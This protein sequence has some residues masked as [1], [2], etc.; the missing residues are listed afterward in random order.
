MWFPAAWAAPPADDPRPAVVGGVPAAPGAWPEVVAVED[1]NGDVGCTGTLVTP[2]LVVTAAHCV[3][4]A[5]A[6]R[7]GDVDPT[8]GTRIPV[9]GV[10]TPGE[11]T[12]GWDVAVLWLAV[13][14]DVVPRPIAADC[15]APVDGET[16]MIVG[17]GATASDADATA[18]P[19]RQ[20]TTRVDDADCGP[21]RGCRPGI[22][23]NGELVAGGGGVDSCR[24]DSG[25]PLYVGD[26]L[27]GWRIAGFASRAADP[28]TVDCGD[29]GI[30]VRADAVADWVEA[31]TGAA[32]TRP[33]CPDAPN[34]APAPIGQTVGAPGGRATVQLDPRDPDAGDG[35][36]WAVV[37]KRGDLVAAIEG[38]TLT[39]Y[40]L[41]DGAVWLRVVDDGVP[42][43]AAL[44]RVDVHPSP[45]EEPPGRG[46]AGAPLG[47]LG[48]LGLIGRVARPFAR[49]SRAPVS[50]TGPLQRS[51]VGATQKR[52]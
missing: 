10:A 14:A 6:V 42:P 48:L 39:V 17:F 32:L 5:V 4:G 30:W 41:A 3:G 43:R 18:V 26:D 7:V 52:R 1:A 40:A 21:D 33:E 28:A 46:C 19:L 31:V 36:V 25:G 23:P 38:D 16:A 35:H 20:A 9:L 13:P 44:L 22:A 2:D 27:Q 29:G 49:T 51:P 24:G 12:R 37:D 45:A 34:R 8:L 11:P 15:A 47:I 50:C